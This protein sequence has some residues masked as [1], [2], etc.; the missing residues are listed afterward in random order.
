MFMDIFGQLL[1]TTA[2]YCVL[3][4]TALEKPPAQ[5]PLD[6]TPNI[7]EWTVVLSGLCCRQ[8]QMAETLNARSKLEAEQE[9][10]TL[11]SHKLRS[12]GSASTVPPSSSSGRSLLTLCRAL[13]VPLATATLYLSR[14]AVAALHWVMRGL[15]RDTKF[16]QTYYK[17]GKMIQDTIELMLAMCDQFAQP[18]LRRKEM[19][20]FQAAFMVFR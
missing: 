9:I 20:D 15:E 17:Q 4:R 8:V 18:E 3:L 6:H 19:L 7:T 16:S 14:A 2:Y 10:T 5:P 11:L 12:P 1:R 13:L